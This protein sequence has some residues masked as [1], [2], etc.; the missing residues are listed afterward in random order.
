MCVS[1]GVCHRHVI[2][3]ANVLLQPTQHHGCGCCGC[4][5]PAPHPRTMPPAPAPPDRLRSPHT[6]PR[7]AG[8]PTGGHGRRS[9][10]AGRA[11]EGHRRDAVHVTRVLCSIPAEAQPDRQQRR[12][13]SRA[14]DRF[15][16]RTGAG[17]RGAGASQTQLVRGG[18]R[19]ELGYRAPRIFQVSLQPELH[20]GGAAR[21]R[22]AERREHQAL[23]HVRLWRDQMGALPDARLLAGG[24]GAAAANGR[25]ATSGSFGAASGAFR[26]LQRAGD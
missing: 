12:R 16:R 3:L 21:Q 7:A 9:V 13:H 10:R 20:P 19:Q 18:E 15:H 25:V 26:A 8:L 22:P 2:Q 14:V 11:V 17:Q 24:G 1:V 5:P 4:S 23:L 6:E